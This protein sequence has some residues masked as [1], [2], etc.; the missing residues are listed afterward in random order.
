MLLHFGSEV[1]ARMPAKKIKE[2]RTKICQQDESAIGTQVVSG[3][4]NDAICNAKLE[5][6]STKIS[7]PALA[8][9]SIRHR[10]IA[11]ARS[12]KAHPRTPLSDAAAFAQA[13]P[14]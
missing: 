14:P 12:C 4:M 2:R 8:A 13:A 5:S 1:T 7:G 10:A 6:E 11:L 3:V 9:W